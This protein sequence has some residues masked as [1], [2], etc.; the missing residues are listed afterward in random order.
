[1]LHNYIRFGRTN[2]NYC[3]RC[4]VE[5]EEGKSCNCITNTVN[6]GSMIKF[7]KSEIHRFFEKTKNRM[8]V[9]DPARNAT[10]T[11]ERNMRIVPDNITADD[12]ETPVKQYNVAVLRNMFRFER[13]EGRLQVTNKRVIFRAAGRS[14]GGRTTL[15]QE[16][17]ID[18]ISGLEASRGY[19][20]SWFHLILGILAVHFAAY[21]GLSLV[22][23]GVEMGQ[24]APSRF[25][26]LYRGAELLSSGVN[27]D[28]GA[29]SIVAGMIIGIGGII[30][31]FMIKRRFLGKLLLLGLSMGSFSAL[32]MT[33]NVFM[34]LLSFVVG[35][36]TLVGQF[37]HCLRPDLKIIIKNKGAQENSPPIEI[38]RKR[39]FTAIGQDSSAGFA[40]VTPTAE[41]EKAIQEIGAIINDIQKLGE[42]ALEKWTK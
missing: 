12:G 33:G 41:T 22:L 26:I 13:A 20:F 1:M 5:I 37:L 38:R 14:I 31:F 34:L 42:Y 39:G 2:M 4:G 9:G 6:I 18:E 27:L 25:S 8:G 35:I 23:S 15:Q 7:D 30:P 29:M 19:R 16:F 21:V 40:E 17:N 28:I 11:Y 24:N 10:D 32:V 36:L 3:E